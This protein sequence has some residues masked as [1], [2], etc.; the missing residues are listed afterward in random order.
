[1]MSSAADIRW[2]ACSL[3]S[4]NF[5]LTRERQISITQ[6]VMR[7]AAVV[8][9]GLFGTR[10]SQQMLQIWLSLMQFKPIPV[11]PELAVRVAPL[12]MPSARR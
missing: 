12:A 11:A 8:G 2:I 5:I 9:I 6:V 4:S 7:A 10:S 1:M 3:S